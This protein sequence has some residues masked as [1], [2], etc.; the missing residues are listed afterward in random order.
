M[1][2]LAREETVQ[3]KR[4]LPY[5]AAW[6]RTRVYEVFVFL[7]S[8]CAG[9]CII[10]YLHWRPTP[11]LVR[12]LLRF[13]SCGYIYGAKYILGVTYKIEGQEHIPTGPVIYM[14]NHLTAW[15]SVMM[16][17]LVPHV[18][19]VTKRA[20]MTIPVFG[21]G[22][23]HAPMTPIDPDTPGKNIRRLLKEG[24]ASIREGRSMV[25]FPEGSRVPIGET[26]PYARGF[27]ILYKHCGVPVVPFVTDSGLHWP[28]GYSTKPPAE[29][30][31]RFLPPIEA[32]KGPNEFATE[33]EETVRTEAAKL[34]G[35]QVQ[36]CET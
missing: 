10:I 7:V 27:E 5:L 24:K 6:L 15:E 14:G 3:S 23:K 36:A 21:W 33:L 1:D 8:I 13:W 9:A 12:R 25:I 35:P 34:L 20:A 26:R 4:L 19:M 22:L 18:N 16:T 31:L 32:G 29:I 2:T 28:S 30:T 17:V 11:V